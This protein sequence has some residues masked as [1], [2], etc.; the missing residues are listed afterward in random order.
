MTLRTFTD[1]DA[2]FITN[3]ITKDI[4]V[5]TNA[6]AISF[7]IKNLILT[8]NGERPFNSDIGTPVKRLLFELYGDTLNIVL[9]KMIS[10]VI[11]NYEPRAVLLQVDIK[12]SPDNNSIYITITYKVVNTEQPITVN[13]ILERTR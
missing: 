12:G 13:V 10:D 8:M 5:K 6:R 2:A 11:Y 7:A 3:P 1:F 4:A 9:R